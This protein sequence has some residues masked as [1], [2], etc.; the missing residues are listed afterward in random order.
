MNIPFD[1]AF[2]IG[3][4]AANALFALGAFFLAEAA[5]G[6]LRA[7][8]QRMLDYARMLDI[9]ASLLTWAWRRGMPTT[10]TSLLV[11]GNRGPRTVWIATRL[12]DDG[13][14]RQLCF[15]SEPDAVE[16]LAA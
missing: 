15:E 12:F 7:R 2:G 4:L 13:S 8:S 16:W 10:A 3:C 6:A 5:R 1:A 9:E 14:F 11:K